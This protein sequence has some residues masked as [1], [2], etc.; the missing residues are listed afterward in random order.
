MNILP[1]LRFVPSPW[2]T[3]WRLSV[4]SNPVCQTETFKCMKIGMQSMVYQPGNYCQVCIASS[5]FHILITVLDFIYQSHG[6]KEWHDSHIILKHLLIR[7]LIFMSSSG[8]RRSQLCYYV[9][10]ISTGY[11]KLFSFPL[12]FPII[13]IYDNQMLNNFHQNVS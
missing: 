12:V 1:I 5:S 7:Y 4:A 2:R 10:S 9:V 13:I 8:C 3:S 11:W 6:I